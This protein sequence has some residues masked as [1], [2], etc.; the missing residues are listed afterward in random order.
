MRP[1]R[2]SR[3]PILDNLTLLGASATRRRTSTAQLCPYDAGDGTWAALNQGISNLLEVRHGANH[4]RSVLERRGSWIAVRQRRL[5]TGG[6]GPLY[7]SLVQP[8]SQASS[9][10]RVWRAGA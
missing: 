3:V 6:T 9:G 5:H 8:I 7:L 2:V 4:H 1:M 10:Q